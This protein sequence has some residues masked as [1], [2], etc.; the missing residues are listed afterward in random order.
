MLVCS[1]VSGLVAMN[2]HP[3]IRYSQSTPPSYIK[4]LAT[5]I[6][7]YMTAYRRSNPEWMPY[8]HQSVSH[9]CCRKR[10]ERSTAAQ[11]S[12]WRSIMRWLPC[13]PLCVAL[14]MDG[15]WRDGKPGEPPEPATLLV[16]DRLDDLAP[17][18]LHELVYSVRGRRAW[19]R[20]RPE[21]ND[22]PV[23]AVGTCSGRQ[24]ARSCLLVTPRAAGDGDRPPAPHAQHGV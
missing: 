13:S 9:L 10:G 21:H 1:V 8:G 7:K 23:P 12:R 16:V 18:L 19:L 20:H 14:Q 2:E 11:R 22:G 5:T 4:S 3:N 15:A 24:R 17:A 6:G